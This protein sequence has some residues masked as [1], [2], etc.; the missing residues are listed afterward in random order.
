M[1]NIIHRGYDVESNPVFGSLVIMEDSVSIYSFEYEEIIQVDPD[2]IS[3]YT[4]IDDPAGDPIF[5]D[6][7][8]S[9]ESICT[10]VKYR[11]GAFYVGNSLLSQ[12]VDEGWHNA[13]SYFEDGALGD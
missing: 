12:I 9:G 10:R 7:F 5:E 13:G 4:G 11:D 8:M 3:Q 2:A 1:R 6:D